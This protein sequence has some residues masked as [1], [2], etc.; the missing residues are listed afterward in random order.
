MGDLIEY[1]SSWLSKEPLTL[2]HPNW[3]VLNRL[4]IQEVEDG[5]PGFRGAL[6][7]AALSALSSAAETGCRKAIAVLAI[8]GL[9]ADIPTLRLAGDQSGLGAD[10]QTAIYEIQH[11]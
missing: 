9:E 1:A 6:R 4:W 8:V 11:R 2:G 10:A 7:E 3:T 5:R